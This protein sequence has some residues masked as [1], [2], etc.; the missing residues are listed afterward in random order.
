MQEFKFYGEEYFVCEPN[1]NNTEYHIIEA[2]SNEIAKGFQKTI[3]K[4]I[5]LVN[6][7]AESQ[8]TGKNTYECC[9]LAYDVL[10][11]RPNVIKE[12]NNKLHS[13]VVFQPKRNHSY[14]IQKD[15]GYI[16]APNDNYHHHKRL[17]DVS[18]GDVIFHVSDKYLVAVST[19]TSKAY[20][21]GNNLRVNC[22]YIIL[23]NEIDLDRYKSEFINFCLG[24]DYAPYDKNGNG[25]QGYLFIPPKELLEFY[26]EKIKEN[27]LNDDW[28][29][30]DN[31]INNIEYNSSPINKS[32]V[33]NE[34]NFNNINMNKKNISLNTILYGPPG[35]GKTY[36]TKVYAVA[37]CNYNGNVETVKKLDYVKDVIPQYNELV[38]KG[39]VAFTT[40]HQSYGYEE[41]IEGIKPVLSEENDDSLDVYYDVIPGVFKKFCDETLINSQN[42]SS[43]GI[44]ENSSIWKISLG[45]KNGNILQECLDEGYIRI[46][47][48][49]NSNDPL[50]I[51]FRDKMK[52]GDIVLSLKS[53]YEINGI[54]QIL[55]NTPIVLDNKTEFKVAKKV[56]WLVKKEINIKDIN[57]GKRLPIKVCSSLPSINK[58]EIYNI[59][60]GSLDNNIKDDEP[61]VFIID[62]INRG[63]ISKIFGELITLIEDTKRKGL[64]EEMSCILPY[65][66]QKFSVPNNIY[67][68]GTMNTADRSIALMDTALRRRFD[69]VEMMPDIETISNIM[70]GKINIE[71]MLNAI[72]ERIEVLYDREHTIGH[73]FFMKLKVNPDIKELA[74]IFENK[75]IP[76]LQE[77]FYEDYFKIQLVLGDNDKDDKFKFIQDE[78]IKTSIFKGKI[79]DD[80]IPENKYK[81]NKDA[82]VEEE[83]YIKIYE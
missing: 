77:Y 46:D 55:D 47:M 9:K 7:V 35:T 25:N 41:F 70:V 60:S 31:I 20:V 64:V 81:I 78:K 61:R 49:I 24:K 28:S 73:A 43:S 80:I 29:I 30:L 42:L 53:F 13:F 57:G 33:T 66:N 36:N 3:A 12:I 34:N 22:E 52:E 40:F 38:E 16:E 15:G 65:S 39:R 14:N 18:I 50:M 5:L 83:S 72:N 19:A 8:I 71:K 21:Y 2:K 74:S 45:G 10:K 62:E 17:N 26:I 51:T 63:N 79:N 58:A 37:I 48:D 23:N 76:L 1:N 44:D 32:S 82:L 67:L 68:L 59:I 69:F 4:Q 56:R 11:N 54:A 75:I 27:N 6:G